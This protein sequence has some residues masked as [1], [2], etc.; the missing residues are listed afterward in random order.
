MLRVS[1]TS[2][3]FALLVLAVCTGCGQSRTLT[4]LH[5]ND[6]HASFLPHDAFWIQSTPKPLVGGFKE[7]WW[8]ADSIR[9]AK[10][11]TPVLLLD[12]GDVMTGTPISEIEYKA[13][14][15]APV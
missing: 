11:D 14:G 2:L 12:G 6:L 5:T 1:R 15:G 3:V 8:T 10:G 4:I 7:L 13:H 9:K